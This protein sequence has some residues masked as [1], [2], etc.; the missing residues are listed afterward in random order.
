[1]TQV[2]PGGPAEAAGILA[3]DVVTTFDGHP[4]EDGTRLRLLAAATP[5]GRVVPVRVAREGKEVELK[6]TIAELP[7]TVARPAPVPAPAAPELA[8]G[9]PE[10]PRPSVGITA[11][12][13]TPELAATFSLPA[14]LTGVVVTEVAPD[15]LAARAG[16]KPGISIRKI[17]GRD[18]GSMAD[19]D[20]AVGAMDVTT[21]VELVLTDGVRVWPVRLLA[22]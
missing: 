5:V 21:G 1:M 11:R 4:V 17:D 13:L 2:A 22:R 9:T 10:T 6:V 18:I 3:G 16:V 12:K 7:A 20:A 8:P 19:L 14:E 15:S